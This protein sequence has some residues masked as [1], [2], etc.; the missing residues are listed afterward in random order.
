MEFLRSIQ[1]LFFDEADQVSDEMFA[2]LDII[3]CRV[4]DSNI[5]MGGV[6]VIMSLDHSQLLPIEGRPF[7][8]SVH[9]I[10][11]VKMVALK[12]SVRASDDA[13]LQRIQ[14]IAR[15]NYRKF[16]ENPAL[17]NEFVRLCSDTFTFV[18]TWDDPKISMSTMRLYSKRV[19]AR[20]AS[21]QFVDQVRRQ[22]EDDSRVERESEDVVKNRYSHRD[23]HGATD[24]VS[25]KLDQHVKES[26]LLLFFKGAIYEATFNDR[27]KFSNTQM[28]MMYDLPSTEA[29]QN[30][31]KVKL[32]KC[33]LGEKEVEFDTNA[34]KKTYLEQGFVEVD[35]GVAPDRTQSLPGN[36]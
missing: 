12:H 33:P 11:C 35:V 18:D 16:H 13:Q 23:W 4:K 30:W 14:Q 32:L 8:T 1:V 25:S 31:R 28:M 10:P 20:D 36:I 27:D 19:P 22:V 6:L 3:F 2:V 34:E 24:H 9:V 26:Q 21:K 29:V 5:F 7:L 17:V 15:M